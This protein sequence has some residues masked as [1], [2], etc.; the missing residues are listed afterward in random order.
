MEVVFAGN[1]A[2]KYGQNNGK[3]V[4]QKKRANKSWQTLGN[5]FLEVVTHSGCPQEAQ[6][7]FNATV[8]G[9]SLVSNWFW[10]LLKKRSLAILK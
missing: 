4:G 10:G 3:Q 5:P 8:L 1:N 2:E 6:I 9:S 7:L